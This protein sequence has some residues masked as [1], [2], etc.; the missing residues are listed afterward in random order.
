M[1]FIRGHFLETDFKIWYVKLPGLSRNRPQ[2]TKVV[3][4]VVAVWRDQCVILFVLPKVLQ[5]QENLLPLGEES[6]DDALGI[7]PRGEVSR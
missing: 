4:P 2:N 3:T 1:G 7:R 6:V 5:L